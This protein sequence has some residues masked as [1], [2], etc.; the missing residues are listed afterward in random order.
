MSIQR[1]KIYNTLTSVKKNLKQRKPYF[2][3]NKNYLE[4]LRRTRTDKEEFR[5][6]IAI[7]EYLI[8]K[9]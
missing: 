1:S 5:E 4:Y 9:R 6:R 2:F 3:D 8:G 7:A